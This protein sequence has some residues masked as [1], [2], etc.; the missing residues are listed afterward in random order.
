MYISKHFYET[1]ELGNGKHLY[2]TAKLGNEV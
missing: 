2:E 1:A